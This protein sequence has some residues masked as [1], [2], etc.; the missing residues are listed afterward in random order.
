MLDGRS[1]SA[2]ESVSRVRLLE[3]GLPA[4]EP[5]YTVYDHRGNVVARS[6][7]GWEDRRTVGEFDG[8][9]KYGRLLKPGQSVADVVYAERLRED[10]I[11]DQGWQVVRWT[12]TDLDRPDIIRDRV[13]RAFQRAA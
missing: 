11:R 4:P 9:V 12:W 8:K 7:F 3:Q 13:L 10:A 5:Q 1:E 6:D 2:G